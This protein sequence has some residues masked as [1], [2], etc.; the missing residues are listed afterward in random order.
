MY[1]ATTAN[2]KYMHEKDPRNE[3]LRNKSLL[4][5]L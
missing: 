2:T 4:I 5:Y 1:I 3:M